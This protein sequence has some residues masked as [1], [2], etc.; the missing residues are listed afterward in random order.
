ML[1]TMG[2][3]R[4]RECLR[5]ALH[6]TATTARR[7]PG[8]VKDLQKSG[9]RPLAIQ[10][11]IQPSPAQAAPSLCL[12]SA[13]EAL[14]PSNTL[15]PGNIDPPRARLERRAVTLRP[16]S[17]HQFATSLALPSSCRTSCRSRPHHSLHPL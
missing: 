10:P 17:A 14:K 11:V 1:I 16:S 7:R 2:G 3:R 9:P 5:N 15:T 13:V 8:P 4:W 12:L 6:R